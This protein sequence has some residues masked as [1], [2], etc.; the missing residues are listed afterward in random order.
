MKQ[1]KC[2]R[3]LVLIGFRSFQN[4]FYYSKA[5]EKLINNDDEKVKL[6]FLKT[7]N[8]GIVCIKQRKHNLDINNENIF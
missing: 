6:L 1:R 3:S 5:T 4:T 7:K 2:V 8:C